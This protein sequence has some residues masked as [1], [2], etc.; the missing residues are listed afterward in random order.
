MR[1][2]CCYCCLVVILLSLA[3][4]SQSLEIPLTVAEPAGIARLGEPVSGGVSL[5]A[6]VF[7]PGTVKLALYHGE[8]PIPLQTTELVIGPQGFVRWVLLDFQLDIEANETENLVLRTGSAVAPQQPLKVFETKAAVKVDT[9][10]IAF[11]IPKNKPFGLVE[12]A[13]AGKKSVVTG[14]QVSYI[15]GLADKRYTA[16]VPSVVKIH[17]AGPMRV[18]IEVRGR[19]PERLKKGRLLPT[20]L[21]TEEIIFSSR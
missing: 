16:A 13:A 12:N 21:P 8:K 2:P 14:G 20:S 7:R 9:G 3:S 17:Y 6:G 1:Y 10:R 4:V 19:F 15:D 11:E 18:T 5:P